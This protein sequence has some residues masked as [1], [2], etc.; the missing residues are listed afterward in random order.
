MIL[1]Q[2]MRLLPALRP[3]PPDL[4]TKDVID[5]LIDT[6]LA[7]FSIA[8]SIPSMLRRLSIT[9]TSDIVLLLHLNAVTLARVIN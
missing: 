1:A 3:P 2:W 4:T 6:L 5:L 9:H 7:I 8:F